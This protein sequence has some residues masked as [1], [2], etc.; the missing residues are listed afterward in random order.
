MFLRRNKCLE[1]WRE[2]RRL[3]TGNVGNFILYFLFQI[4][5][6]MVIGTM[7]LIVVLVTCCIAGCLMLLPFL[8]TVLL[9]PVHVFNR[10]Y[11][12]HFLAQF[13]PEFDVFPPEPA[14]TPGAIPPF[15]TF[16]AAA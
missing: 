15:P 12:L 13:G 1:G 14:M 10:A 9:L 7:V 16:G 11:S 6:G 2:L 4:V 3:F 8:G 5:L